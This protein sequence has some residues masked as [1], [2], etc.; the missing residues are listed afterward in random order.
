MGC[1]I[2]AVIGWIALF[3]I[4]LNFAAFL[5]RGFNHQQQ[6]A[7]AGEPLMGTG[8]GP[9]VKKE[10]RAAVGLNI[11]MAVACLIYL[12]VLLNFW[13]KS[14]AFCGLILIVT[15]I[16]DLLIKFQ[17]GQDAVRASKITP[18]SV[19]IMVITLATFPLLWW[20]AC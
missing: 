5:L 11:F 16:P 17:G 12:F 6:L 19:V 13:G 3:F 1:F 15:R 20:S 9:L 4:G 8:A 14:V 7:K 18:L 2:I 10:I